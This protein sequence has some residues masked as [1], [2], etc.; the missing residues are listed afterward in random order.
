MIAAEL[1]VF[2]IMDSVMGICVFRKIRFILAKTQRTALMCT[3]GLSIGPTHLFPTHRLSRAIVPGGKECVSSSAGEFKH[4]PVL[5]TPALA[6]S[7]A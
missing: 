2:P 3:H 4:C 1:N 5:L 6:V 7:N